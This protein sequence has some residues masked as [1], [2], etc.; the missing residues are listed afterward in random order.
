MTEIDRSFERLDRQEKS[1]AKVT[2]YG[3]TKQGQALARHHLNRLAEA[4]HVER[5]SRRGDRAVWR[6][7]KDRDDK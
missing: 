3:T 2:G 7:L 1:R 6:A 4:I 5:K